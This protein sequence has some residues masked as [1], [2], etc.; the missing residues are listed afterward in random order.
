MIFLERLGLFIQKQPL[1]IIIV[2]LTF[3]VGLT[4][5]YFFQFIY[6]IL[7]YLIFVVNAKEEKDFWIIIMSLLFLLSL[8]NI[9]YN[10]YD[11]VSLLSNIEVLR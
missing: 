1:L 6:L 2:V 8:G 7:I 9:V 4:F 5:N 3:I 11:I 10:F